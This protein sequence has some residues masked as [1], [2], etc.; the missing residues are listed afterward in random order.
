MFITIHYL[1]L[2]YVCKHH[3]YGAREWHDDGAGFDDPSLAMQLNQSKRQLM[4]AEH[5]AR[6]LH[7]SHFYHP[8]PFLCSEL[9]FFLRSFLFFCCHLQFSHFYPP[10]PVLSSEFFFLCTFLFFFGIFTFHTFH[11]MFLY[12]STFLHY[13]LLTSF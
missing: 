1:Y 9:S 5:C 4:V 8:H 2:C 10:H 11:R 7:F 12:F 6:H 13:S 3:L